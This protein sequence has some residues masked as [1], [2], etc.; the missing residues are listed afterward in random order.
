M[1]PHVPTDERGVDPG[2]TNLEQRVTRFESRNVRLSMNIVANAAADTPVEERLRLQIETM[3]VLIVS[4]VSAGALLVGLGS[5]VAMLILRLTSPDSV[6]G[7]ESD[8]GFTIGEVTIGGTYN[9]LQLGAVVGIIGAAAYLWVAPWLIGPTWFRRLTTGLAAAAVA[10]SMLVHADGI[11]FTVLK[12]TWLAIGLFVA[13][14]GVFGTLIGSFVDAVRRADS[15]TARGSRRWVLA[16]VCVACFPVT[17]FPLTIALIV[18]LV[19]AIVNGAGLVALIRRIP[20]YT[21]IIR[22][23]WLLVAVAGLVALVNDINQI[24]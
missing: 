16:L 14:P 18:L 11:D 4:G 24:T 21:F 19:W 15:W 12:P 20:A 3:R 17:V 23:L 6:H 5:R 7:V 13:L 8:D 22:S 2:D 9:L 1:G 10:G